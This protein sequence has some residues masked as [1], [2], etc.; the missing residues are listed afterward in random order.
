MNKRRIVLGVSASLLVLGGATACG[1]NANR[2]LKGVSSMDPDYAEVYNNTDQRPNI[3]LLC[4]RGVGFA[5]TTRDYTSVLRVPEWDSF[6]KQ[7]KQHSIVQSQT[8]KNG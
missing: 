7:F 3:G 2:D 1:N 8:R 5:T 6:C 4:I